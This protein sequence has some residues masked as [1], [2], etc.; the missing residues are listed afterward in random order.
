LAGPG[1]RGAEATLGAPANPLGQPPATADYRRK[2]GCRPNSKNG[3]AKRKG[4]NKKALQ[5]I[6][7]ELFVQGSRQISNFIMQDVDIIL[8]HAKLVGVII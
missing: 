2:P 5:R 4:Q 8:H 3:T 6:V 1:P 7:A